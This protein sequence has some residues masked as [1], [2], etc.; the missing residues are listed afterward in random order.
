M[1]GLKF[2]TMEEVY[3]SLSLSRFPAPGNIFF[4]DG[5]NGLN[6]NDG[7]TPTSAYLTLTY[8]LAQCVSNR[9]DIIYVLDYW[10]PAGETFPI[11]VNK[12]QVHIIGLA[13]PNLSY[14]AI[15]PDGDTAA[16]E[17]ANTGQYSEIANLMIGGGDAHG[18]IETGSIANGMGNGLYVHDCWFGHEWFDTPLSGIRNLGTIN[19]CGIR[20]ERCSFFGDQQN[21]IGVISGNGIDNALGAAGGHFDKCKVLDC[22]FMGVSSAIVFDQA[23]DS[24]ILNN[25]FNGVD[26]LEGSAINLAAGAVGCL[27]D[28]NSVASKKTTGVTTN[29]WKDA[30]TNAWGVNYVGGVN[31]YPA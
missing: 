5:V 30:G 18:G 31:G 6:T 19:A 28:G 14:P 17:I 23:R 11:L 25:R 20:I 13:L 3:K 16:F 29:P 21:C 26:N 8:A 2:T 7:G 12:H 15:H 27:I 10:Q 4:V 22:I 1:A 9:N 24:M